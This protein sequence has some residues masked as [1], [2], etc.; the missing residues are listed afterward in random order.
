[1]RLRPGLLTNAAA[2]SPRA[3]DPTPVVLFDNSGA[4]MASGTSHSASITSTASAG[5]VVVAW[6][7]W[8]GGAGNTI[9]SVASNGETWTAGTRNTSTTA[10]INVQSYM[11]VLTSDW[12]PAE[13]FTFNLS[14]S[15]GPAV[16]IVAYPSG[17]ALDVNPAGSSGSG[18]TISQTLTG[19]GTPP[20]YASACYSTGSNI[21]TYGT[22]A[23][24]T[25][26]TSVISGTFGIRV[27]S[28]ALSTASN[29][30]TFSVTGTSTN[31]TVN[32]R[33]LTSSV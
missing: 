28:K 1:M 23:T 15:T 11:A 3:V 13:Q 7:C 31:W 22:P 32:Y 8:G 20:L 14:S 9:S 10:N 30:T 17:L 24:W 29:D 27:F 25:L 5:W 2:L 12:T 33:T 21:A 16:V 26:L 6:V 19:M 18:T 4:F